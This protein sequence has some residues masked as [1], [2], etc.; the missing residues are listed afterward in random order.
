MR[1]QKLYRIFSIIFAM[2]MLV[3]CSEDSIAPEVQG[4]AIEEMD[5]I[6]VDDANPNIPVSFSAKSGDL[7]GV[8]VTV[9]KEGS[10]D[11]TFK[12]SVK[13]ITHDNLNRIKLNVPFPTPD[14]APSG[15]Y[16][17]SL[18]VDGAEESLK[19]MKVNVL[20][21]RTI[22][23][24]DFPAPAAGKVTVFVSVPGG[25]DVAEAGK[26]I[27]IVGNFMTKNGAA[28]DWNPGN[29]DFKLTK[30][31][32][33]CYYIVL[34][35][36][37]AGDMFKLT[38]G[39]WPVEFLG[40]KGEGMSDQRAPGGNVY[41][42]AYNFKTLPVK[43]YEVPE[44]LPTEAIKTGKMTAIFDV[45]TYSADSKYYLVEKGANT[46]DGAIEMKNV[47]GTTKVAAAGDKNSSKEYVVVKDEIGNV[48]INAYGFE[49]TV[50]W[51]GA[52]NPA[53][54]GVKN[55][56]DNVEVNFENVF[57]VGGATPGGWSNPVPTPDQQ[58]TK[59]AEGKYT[60]TVALKAN[61]GYLFLPV[62]GSWDNKWGTATGGKLS[63]DL[64]WAGSDF[65]S[66]AEAGTY[67]IDLDF[68]KGAYGT[69]TLTKQ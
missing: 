11:I 7:N 32:E 35:K 57:M 15:V 54:N 5:L 56:G 43:Q 46:L 59:S 2:L 34:D 51:D 41:I 49:Q 27:Y 62:N 66:P 16:N 18:A 40:P 3:R 61:E 68:T 42:T 10:P 17:V 24:C 23:Y 19:T 12:N 48:G 22:K 6:Q 9:T 47:A 39:D 37:D 1:T 13:Q 20:N 55:F 60:L 31:G 26:D 44:L 30:L 14:F 45:G 21:N 36:L 52:T 29:P 8:T 64:R 53:S 65:S 38:L 63:G 50:K 67:K 28:G 58:F 33:Q 25:A 4:I 69:Y